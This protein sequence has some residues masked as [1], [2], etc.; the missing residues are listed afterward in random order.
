MLPLDGIRVLEFTHAVLGPSTGMYLAD[1]GAEVIKVEPAPGGDPTRRLQGFGMG[2]APFTNRNKK[3][4]AVNLK[5]DEGKKVVYRL[6][7][8]AV[9]LIENFGPGT[10][11]RLGF[12]YDDLREKY[13]GLIYCSLKGFM[14]GPYEKRMALDEVVQMMSGL[15]YMTGRPGDPL[16]AGASVVDIMTGMNGVIGILLA[17]REREQT[18]KG[19]LVKS[20][21]FETAAFLM[22][23]HMAYAAMSGQSVPPMPTR[24]SAWGIYHQFEVADGGRVFIGV[25][26]DSQWAR[27][28]TEFGRED[29]LQDE[30]IA[31][32]NGRVKNQT[33]LLPAIQELV[34]PMSQNDVLSRCEKA[35]LP[36]SPIARP[37]DLF[38][39]VQLNEG[40]G[41][42]E[43]TLPNGR[44]IKLPKLP[45]R[46]GD[47]DFNI[48]SD[49]PEIGAHTAEILQELG[50]SE[51]EIQ[52][53]V[54]AN[55]VVT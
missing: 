11:E 32:N 10:M 44:K 14:P 39:D 48:R 27:F 18:G 13:P 21:L 25:T 54:S 17:L 40:G 7:E 4:L 20:T 12:G 6:L 16:R 24:V 19:Q 45:I 15:A 8:T 31:T 23:Q 53:F 38:D 2:F 36:F 49:P 34:K 9:I 28:C 26:S 55:I 3:S 33:W 42:L 37:E 5:S 50:Y 29:W 22:G 46:L 47:E 52:E 43:T 41:L 30:R 51:E 35:N 1:F